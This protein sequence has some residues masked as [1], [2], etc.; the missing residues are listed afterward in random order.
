MECSPVWPDRWPNTCSCVTAV[1]I[2][3]YHSP[4][5]AKGV[6]GGKL[7]KPACCFTDSSTVTLASL[8]PTQGYALSLK[9]YTCQVPNDVWISAA[10][11]EYIVLSGQVHR[12]L[13]CSL[14]FLPPNNEVLTFANK[15]GVCLLILFC[16]LGWVFF[17]ILVGSF[18][19]DGVVV[20]CFV[21]GFCK[22]FLLHR[23]RKITPTSKN[24][25]WK[26]Y[27]T[28]TVLTSC[29]SR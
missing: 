14:Q 21:L 11:W 22:V 1:S 20:V 15:C 29:P 2:T 3:T 9:A 5:L 27:F 4:P 13:H 18:F 25:D 17:P 23:E 16:C 28:L 19:S 7:W 26:T 10:A 8:N 6:L 12:A 24:E